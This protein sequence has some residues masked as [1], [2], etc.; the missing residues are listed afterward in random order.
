[1]LT[2]LHRK[3]KKLLNQM[4]YYFFV[5]NS[6]CIGVLR[7]QPLPNSDKIFKI[8]TINLTG[9]MGYYLMGK[10]SPKRMIKISKNKDLD[11][12]KMWMKEVSKL[13]EFHKDL[14]SSNK[15]DDITYIV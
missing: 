7:H 3:N 14:T 5:M 10:V 6:N 2:I 15:S 13:N 8:N 1:M 9:A 11:F 12:H 4:L